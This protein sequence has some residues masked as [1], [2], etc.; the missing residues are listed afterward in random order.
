MSET[1]SR[2]WC[3][4]ANKILTAS[5]ALKVGQATGL[6]L[7]N[8]GHKHTVIIGKDTRRSSYMIENALTAGFLA[9]GIHVQLPG[10]IP[11][12]AVGVL[13]RSTRSDLGVMISAGDLPFEHNGI[14][15]FGSDGFPLSCEKYDRIQKLIDSEAEMLKELIKVEKDGLGRAERIDGLKD[16]YIEY[17]KGAVPGLKLDGMRVIIDC[18]NGSAYEVAPKVLKEL[19]AEVIPMG[20]EPYGTNI[21]ADCGATSPRGMMEKVKELRADIGIALDGDGDSVILADEKGRMLSTGQ[22]MTMIAGGEGKPERP[23]AQED[24][25]ILALQVLAAVRK[26]GLRMSETVAHMLPLQGGK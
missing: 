11:T 20:V 12:P 4:E 18:A 26:T 1:T 9:A 24:G 13:V 3:G 21:N 22:I 15:L 7:K 23:P 17:A 6:T 19:G 10:P 2:R 25:F 14:T 5:L 8:G 16:R